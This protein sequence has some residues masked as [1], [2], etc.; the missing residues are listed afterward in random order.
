MHPRVCEPWGTTFTPQCVQVPGSHVCPPPVCKPVCPRVPPPCASPCVP[1]T[2][3]TCASPVSPRHV[4]PGVPRSRARRPRPW[5]GRPVAGPS[6]GPVPMQDPVP[7]PVPGRPR[8]AA[9]Q[10]SPP[11]PATPAPPSGPA[12]GST[13]PGRAPSPGTAAP[14][15]YGGEGKGGWWGRALCS[16]R[17][18]AGNDARWGWRGRCP[19]PVPSRAHGPDRAR[20][21]PGTRPRSPRGCGRVF[22]FRGRSAFL[23]RDPWRVSA[24]GCA[25]PALTI[26]DVIFFLNLRY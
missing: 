17:G 21:P 13:A 22:Q 16:E 9:P 25:N 24:Q 8:R 1:F 26:P 14:R 4:K 3:P 6:P 2:P 20:A 11:P 15:G 10:R 23:R 12:G 7:D 5:R 18:C 19:P